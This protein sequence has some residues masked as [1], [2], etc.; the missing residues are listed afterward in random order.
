M[1]RMSRVKDVVARRRAHA[2][3]AGAASLALAFALMGTLA[4]GALAAPTGIFAKFAQCPTR[5]SGVLLCNY[6]EAVSGEFAIGK[7]SV[8][9][10]RTFVFQGG[11]IE[12]GLN[13]YFMVPVAGGEIFS[14]NEMPIPGGLKALMNCPQAG[15]PGLSNTSNGVYVTL[16]SAASHQIPATLNLAAAIFEE[17]PALTLPMR[18]QLHNPALGSTCFIGSE[19]HPIELRLTDGAT[20]P[21]PPGQPMRGKL[22]QLSEQEED[23]YGMTV[24][25]G[26]KVVDNTF[27]VPV[28]TGCGGALA[29][30]IDLEIDRAL[31]LPSAAGRNAA[32]LIANLDIAEA[33][34]IRASETF[35]RK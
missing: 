12:K 18:L 32:V 5:M 10:T 14:T 19:T 24:I 26:A 1:A 22:G 21:P 23:G 6:G 15:C 35:P 29:G 16:K 13:Y 31:G 4:S 34:S 9:F 17:E 27:S 33:A 20:S 8:P 2:P 28:A 25:G 11:D 3:K 7:L 30:L